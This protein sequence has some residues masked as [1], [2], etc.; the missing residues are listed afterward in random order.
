MEFERLTLDDDGMTR[1]YATLR[2]HHHIRRSTQQIRDF[3]FSFV[4]P[5]GTNHYNVSQGFIESS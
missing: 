1:I 3:S 5:L 2:T 4:A